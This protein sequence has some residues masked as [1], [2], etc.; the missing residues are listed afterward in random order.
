M[1]YG[2]SSTTIKC[3]KESKTVSFDVTNQANSVTISTSDP[4]RAYIDHIVICDGE[5]NVEQVEEL[6]S[7]GND[8][9]IV[10]S[11]K[12]TLYKDIKDTNHLFSNLTQREY[13]YR[14]KAYNTND[15]LESKWSNWIK[16]VLEIPDDISQISDE[17]NSNTAEIYT[18][19]GIKME[20]SLNAL[21][22][23]IYL[24]RRGNHVEKV[25]KK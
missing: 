15:D 20:S 22:K 12:S 3:S 9:G 25:M 24:I 14:V 21:P 4:T 19:G 6:L 2:G 7:S 18:L 13:E 10:S 8:S 11:T 16:V 5:A 17:T 1:T 23:G